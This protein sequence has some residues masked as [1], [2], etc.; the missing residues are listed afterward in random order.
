MSLFTNSLAFLLSAII[1]AVRDAAS[2]GGVSIFL[3]ISC[4]LAIGVFI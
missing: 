3:T 4:K 2:N 1:Q